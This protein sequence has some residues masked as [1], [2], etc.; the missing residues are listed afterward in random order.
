[1]TDDLK[2]ETALM[3]FH[4]QQLSISK[5]KFHSSCKKAFSDLNAKYQQ[6][7]LDRLH[8]QYYKW[9]SQFWERIS[10]N[11]KERL[12]SCQNETKVAGLNNQN[13][14]AKSKECRNKLQT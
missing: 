1:M 8:Q 10:Q 6:I 7:L 5:Q 11:L 12:E 13:Q 14:Q 2:D 9:N 3:E 4:E